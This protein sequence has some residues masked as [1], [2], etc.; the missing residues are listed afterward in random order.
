MRHSLDLSAARPQLVNTLVR[1]DDFVI[2]VCDRAYETYRG[3]TAHWSVPDPAPTGSD[4]EFEAAFAD[5]ARR[6]SQLAPR[7]LA[8]D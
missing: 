3:A 4:Q 7:L 6:V 5:L 8:L 2:T 1:D